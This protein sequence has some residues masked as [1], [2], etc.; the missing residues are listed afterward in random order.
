MSPYASNIKIRYPERLLWEEFEDSKS[1]L[2]P[3]TESLPT[4]KFSASE[5]L[6]SSSPTPNFDSNRIYSSGYKK[7]LYPPSLSS[8]VLHGKHNSSKYLSDSHG[9]RC[10]RFGC[11]Q[12]TQ[13]GSYY[14]STHYRANHQHMV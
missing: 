14:C 7:L 8:S 9:Y 12:L 2:D 1:Y 5:Y 11:G 3:D 6:R 13:L 10:L 4:P